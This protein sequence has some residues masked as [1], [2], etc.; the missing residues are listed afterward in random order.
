MS[1]SRGKLLHHVREI[2]MVIC[3][4]ILTLVPLAIWAAWS[5]TVMYVVL[6]VCILTV[7]SVI[8]LAQI[9]GDE[10]EVSPNREPHD[11]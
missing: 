10:D 8:A 1:L 5:K 3:G 11:P 7:A 9:D 2:G 6:T 4:V